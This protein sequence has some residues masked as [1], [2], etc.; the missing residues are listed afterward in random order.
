MCTVL[1]KGF[2]S[3]LLHY[4]E[5]CLFT[6]IKLYLFTIPFLFLAYTDRILCLKSFDDITLFKHKANFFAS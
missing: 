6:L 3:F 5:Y 1:D 4:F 2:Y